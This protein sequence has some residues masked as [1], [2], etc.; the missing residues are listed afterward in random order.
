VVVFALFALPQFLGRLLR[1][2]AMKEEWFVLVR[3]DDG[4]YR[5]VRASREVYLADPWLVVRD[6]RTYLFAESYDYRAGR[7][8]IVVGEL[9]DDG[10]IDRLR[11]A[12]E[13]P[14]HL[15]YPC[16]FEFGGDFYMIPESRAHSALE[17][18][19]AVSFPDEWTLD[20]VLF[21]NVY[22]VD[23]T[24]VEHDGRLWL[25]AAIAGSEHLASDDELFLFSAEDPRGPWTPHPANPIV[26]DV[27]H[28]R[29]AG[30]IVPSGDA[31]V[32]PAQDCLRGYG[33]A[34]SL[35]RIE[36]LTTDGYA[37]REIG[38]ITHRDVGVRA[39]DVHT[40]ARAGRFEA[41]DARRFR[42]RL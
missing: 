31:M 8:S 7:G 4:P 39:S 42:P 35:R 9:R 28:A 21:E 1:H 16:V 13:R 19:R 36:R 3:V 24:V 23:P 5:R 15:S 25:F 33:H 27:R 18:Y 17:L 40:Y 20:T 12:L 14:Y 37:E 38:R 26:S 11:P 41:V 30:A 29:P 34:V 22:A 2:L 32:R 6:G 10:S